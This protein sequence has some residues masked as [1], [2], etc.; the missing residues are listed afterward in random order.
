MRL[1]SLMIFRE[2]TDIWSENHIK[3]VNTLSLKNE[4]N[5]KV[6]CVHGNHCALKN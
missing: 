6:C 2:I 4:Q 1:H 3:P 5:T